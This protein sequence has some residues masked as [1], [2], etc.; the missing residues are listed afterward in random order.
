M[1]KKQNNK[2]IAKPFVK[3]AGGKGSLIK[4]LIAYLPSNFNEQEDVTYI[5]PF[6]GG[7]S[8][9]FQLL[10][11]NIKVNRYI[12]SDINK[13]LIDLWN[14]IKDEP[15]KLSN[16]YD[17]MWKELN[18]DE[19]VDRKKDYYYTVRDRF[20]KTKNPVDFLFLSRTCMN[21]LI[22][23]N[24]KG[25]FNTSFHFSRPGIHPD[26]LKDIIF[27]W[28][29]LLNKYNVEFICQDYKNVNP[30]TDD[31]VY[32]DPPYISTKGMYYGVLDYNNFWEYLRNLKSPFALSFNGC[33]SGKEL[34]YAIPEDIY[35][36]HKFLYSGVSSLK[37]M[38]CKKE[39]VLESLYIKK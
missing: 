35:T 4:Q 15:V 11:S 3:W 6:V 5:E 13:D 9:L 21:G 16:S 27:Q 19:D 29:E 25:K 33:V 36:E 10:N 1:K 12:C 17:K 39:E 26:K 38:H 31:Y 32:L 14:F 24:S 7:G 37:K 22:R 34:Q 2:I 23:Y 20:N 30:S 18:K 8:V 28:S